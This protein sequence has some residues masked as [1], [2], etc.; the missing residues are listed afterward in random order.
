[1][2]QVSVIVLNYNGK[3][4]L[5]E[6][7]SSVL[8]QKAGT[9]SYEL[10]VVDNGSNDGSVEYLNDIKQPVKKVLLSH[11]TGFCGGVNAGISESEAEYVILLN[12]DTKVA[13]DFILCLYN[14]M[15]RHKK[16][17]SIN[18][19]M[20]MWDNPELLDDAGDLYNLAGWSFARGKG[21]KASRY[22]KPCTLFSSCAGAAIYNRRILC[23]IGLFDEAHFAYYEDLDVGYRAMINGYR[24]YYEPTAKV[25]HYGSASSGS[26]YNSFKAELTAANS[27]YVPFKNMPI[28]QY[29]INMP[30]LILGALTK[31]LFYTLKGMGKPYL[32]GLIKGIKKSFSKQGFA[33][34]VPYRFKNTANYL[35]IEAEMIINL[36]RFITKI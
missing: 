7:I 8:N 16:A 11:N 6:C 31:L 29:L 15:Q 18:A 12:N 32:R 19:Q 36:F 20:L 2:I 35:L 17:F 27:V 24:S 3:A 5:P 30:F 22:N 26:R 28:L 1:M 13:E 14:A 21:R 33:R 4:F 10:I 23:E 25:I 34:K 9:P